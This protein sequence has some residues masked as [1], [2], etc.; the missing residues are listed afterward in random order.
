MPY[1]VYRTQYESPIGEA[2]VVVTPVEHEQRRFS[3]EYFVLYP[4]LS[5]ELIHDFF[6]IGIE[7]GVSLS[8]WFNVAEQLTR[9]GTLGVAL[10]DVDRRLVEAYKAGNRS[11]LPPAQVEYSEVGRREFIRLVVRDLCKDKLNTVRDQTRS[12]ELSEFLRVVL[13]LSVSKLD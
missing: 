9:E 7:E 11:T 6:T 4:D 1:E 3:G 12:S 8:E 2:V 10:D 5:C 13:T